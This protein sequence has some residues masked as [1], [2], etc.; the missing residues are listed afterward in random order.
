MIFLLSMIFSISFGNIHLQSYQSML[1]YD[2]SYIT[3]SNEFLFI[4]TSRCVTY[5]LSFTL[6]KLSFE[7][8]PLNLF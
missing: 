8:T 6:D 5:A 4:Q 1:H 3:L 7:Q 2:H